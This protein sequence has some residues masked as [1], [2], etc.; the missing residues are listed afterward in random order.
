MEDVSGLGR[1]EDILFLFVETHLSR[2]NHVQFDLPLLV[3][4]AVL[5][6][7]VFITSRTL[8]RCAY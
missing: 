6:Q 4:K 1:H 5:N 7:N 8:F 2:S 3:D